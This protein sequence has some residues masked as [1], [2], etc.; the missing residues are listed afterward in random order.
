MRD[1]LSTETG[2]KVMK[3]SKS[4]KNPVWICHQ[5][6]QALPEPHLDRWKQPQQHPVR[7][8]H[9]SL[10]CPGVD[11]RLF[12]RA[13]TNLKLLGLRHGPHPDHAK[14]NVN[15]MSCQCEVT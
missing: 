9:A 14:Q 8:A 11:Q 15:T 1:L 6:L 12:L 10:G 13:D 5:R 3:R 4:D 7:H 2:Q